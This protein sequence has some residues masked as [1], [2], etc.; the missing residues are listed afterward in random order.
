MSAPCAHMPLSHCSCASTL[1]CGAAVC[2]PGVEYWLLQASVQFWTGRLQALCCIGCMHAFARHQAQ[3]HY[4][5][6]LACYGMW[7]RACMLFAPSAANWDTRRWKRRC[8]RASTL[9]RSFVMQQHLICI[10]G[11]SKIKKRKDCE[12]CICDVVVRPGLMSSSLMCLCL[13]SCHVMSAR[14][15]GMFL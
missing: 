3:M 2:V 4:H 1:F 10:F 14:W 6:R 12:G 7:L 15:H 8:P 9:T 5:H 13:A 11:I